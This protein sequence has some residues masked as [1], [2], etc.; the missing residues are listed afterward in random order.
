MIYPHKMRKIKNWSEFYFSLDEAQIT[1]PL[2]VVGY[3][4]YKD[5]KVTNIGAT[6][7]YSDIDLALKSKK[8]QKSKIDDFEWVTDPKLLD[9]EW[10]GKTKAEIKGILNSRKIDTSKFGTFNP[11]ATPQ[12]G[13]S[14][15]THPVYR[16][17]NIEP[18]SHQG[19]I[20]F[21]ETKEGS[22]NFYTGMKGEKMEAT[23]YQI[24]LK[25]PFYINSFWRDYADKYSSPGQREQFSRS[26]I[27]KGYDGIFFHTDT[28]N[29]TGDEHAVRSEQYV[30][31]DPANVYLMP[32][33]K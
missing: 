20:W 19:G 1:E 23:T 31:F 25:N 10:I 9:R 6:E 30:V 26:L 12:L 27:D 28:W 7:F 21:A 33:H 11:H 24:K 4:M 16:I 8:E 17:G 13:G 5:G 2:N 15:V 18:N 22:E 14:K 32:K 29:D 3:L